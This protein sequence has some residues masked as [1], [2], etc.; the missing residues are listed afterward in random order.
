MVSVMEMNLPLR[1]RIRCPQTR[2]GADK[3]ALQDKGEDGRQHGGPS[4]VPSGYGCASH[5]SDIYI[6][7]RRLLRPKV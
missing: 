1:G 5:G 3:K 4:S 2:R 6:P 7:T